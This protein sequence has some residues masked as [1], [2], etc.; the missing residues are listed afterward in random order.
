MRFFL[1]QGT[2][3]VRRLCIVFRLSSDIGNLNDRCLCFYRDSHTQF[4]SFS[5]WSCRLTERLRAVIVALARAT[6]WRH[7]ASE[8][9]R[10]PTRSS[11]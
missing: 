2:G 3:A 4:S 5:D 10:R 6:Y 11:T 1:I 8:E 7:G 9:T